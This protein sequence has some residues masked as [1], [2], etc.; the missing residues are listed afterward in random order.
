MYY[1]NVKYNNV[2]ETV[3][4]FEKRLEARE[5]V[6]EYN[7]SDV[8]NHYYISQRSTKEWHNKD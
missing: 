6:K 5:M 1:I 8:Y 2:V 4:E 3:D 7:I